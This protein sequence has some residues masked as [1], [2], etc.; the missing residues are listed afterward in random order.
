MK[1]N[2]HRTILA[3]L[4]L[5]VVVIEFLLLED[6]LVRF[7]VFLFEMNVLLHKKMSALNMACMIM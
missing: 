3:V 2:L 5:I 6:I 1:G 4:N 7:C